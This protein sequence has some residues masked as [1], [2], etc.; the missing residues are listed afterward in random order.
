VTESHTLP[1]RVLNPA[2]NASHNYVLSAYCMVDPMPSSRDEA[3][4]KTICVEFTL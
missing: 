2:M 4:N 3:A 1:C